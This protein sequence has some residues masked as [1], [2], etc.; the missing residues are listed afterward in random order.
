MKKLSRGI[1]ILHTLAQYIH[2]AFG[3]KVNLFYVPILTG[4]NNQ[5]L[6]N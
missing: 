6:C 4:L 3:K 2:V 5:H 1:E